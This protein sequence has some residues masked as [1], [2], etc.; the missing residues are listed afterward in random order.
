MSKG[1]ASKHANEDWRFKHA[2]MW[3]QDHVKHRAT[4]L[5]YLLLSFGVMANA[6][7]ALLRDKNLLVAGWLASCAALVAYAFLCLDVITLRKIQLAK[8]VLLQLSGSNDRCS[9]DP[10]AAAFALILDSSLRP[11]SRFAGTLR[12]HKERLWTFVI[13][14]GA[15]AIAVLAAVDA[16]GFSNTSRLIVATALAAILIPVG[17]ATIQASPLC[18]REAFGSRTDV[19]SILRPRPVGS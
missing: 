11:T 18:A 16:F 12:L 17:K 9:E 2:W 1:A 10:N 3:Y 13:G 15:T 5:N 4:L 6:Y 8:G 7:V 14:S 19:G